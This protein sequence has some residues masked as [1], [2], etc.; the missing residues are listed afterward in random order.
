MS[1]QH[2]TEWNKKHIRPCPTGKCKHLHIRGT[3]PCTH[4]GCGCHGSY[5]TGSK[6]KTKKGGR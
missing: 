2:T 1:K 4:A 5:G 3:G 6:V